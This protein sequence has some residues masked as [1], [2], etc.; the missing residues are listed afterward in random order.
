[1]PENTNTPN[2]GK[3]FY[4]RHGVGLIAGGL[5]IEALRKNTLD[6]LPEPKPVLNTEPA[7]QPIARIPTSI[8][9]ADIR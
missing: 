3:S 2:S 1:M 5:V 9:L 6:T 8:R 7:T 4:N